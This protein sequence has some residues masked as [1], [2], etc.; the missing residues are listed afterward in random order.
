MFLM[1]MVIFLKFAGVSNW[2]PAGA[3]IWSVKREK[4]KD[5]VVSVSFCCILYLFLL[6]PLC[7]F[8]S[9]QERDTRRDK[10]KINHRLD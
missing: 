1:M 6:F 2:S 8:I 3:R 7:V 5:L 4:K 10:Q 9:L